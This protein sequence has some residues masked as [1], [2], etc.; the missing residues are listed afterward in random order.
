MEFRSLLIH[1]GLKGHFGKTFMSIDS[2]LSSGSGSHDSQSSSL[3]S[4]MQEYQ[5]N[6]K[7]L[8]EK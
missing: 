1:F 8:L 7:L 6:Q 4:V 3:S 5:H 2:L